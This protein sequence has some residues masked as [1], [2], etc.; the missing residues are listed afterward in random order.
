M[1]PPNSQITPADSAAPG[2]PPLALADAIDAA[3]AWWRDAGVDGAL[4]DA[5]RDWLATPDQPK[6]RGRQTGTDTTAA[7]PG[8]ALPTPVETAQ[9]GGGPAAWPA[10]IAEFAPWW[11][12]EPTLAP[13]GAVRVPPAGPVAPALMIVVPMPEA[14]DHDTLLSGKAGIM[15]DGLLAAAGLSRAAIYCAAA[16]PAR[17]T[18][19]DWNALA[20]DGLGAL[21]THHITLVAP[22]RLIVF[23]QNG[24]STLLGNDSANKSPGLPVINH[25]GAL[26]PS[27]FAYELDA[28]VARPA[29]KA[30]LWKSW[31]DWMPA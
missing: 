3:L 18:A 16:L 29:L 15:L 2:R 20:N 10:T 8:A 30:G 12:Q 5:P 22:R 31:L 24:I 7:S 17:I 1:V 19:P 4:G 9:I 26:L 27:L 25:N 13:A 21:L 14:D 28:Y 6:K 23:G 11:M